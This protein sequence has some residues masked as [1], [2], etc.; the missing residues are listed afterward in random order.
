M[1]G[2]HHAHHLTGLSDH[3]SFAV[4]RHAGSHI[5]RRADQNVA[6]NALLNF[7]YAFGSALGG[8]QH[9]VLNAVVTGF[10]L[11]GPYGQ[12]VGFKRELQFTVG[13]IR[14]GAKKNAIGYV[15]RALQAGNA[16]VRF[17]AASFIAV[18]AR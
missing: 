12:R 2:Q 1:I 18:R 3:R 11:F 4:Q 7:L 5:H 9:H 8:F 13:E 15:V 6:H 17:A 10:Q 16:N 14:I